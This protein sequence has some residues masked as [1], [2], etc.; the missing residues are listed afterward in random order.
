[1]CSSSLRQH[2]TSLVL[3][4]QGILPPSHQSIIT[5]DQF[6]RK[7]NLVALKR[8]LETSDFYGNAQS[9]L[10]ERICVA[11]EG[12]RKL[13]RLKEAVEAGKRLG[14]RLKAKAFH[15]WLRAKDFAELDEHFQKLKGYTLRL[16]KE[17][18]ALTSALPKKI[19]IET[20]QTKIPAH[21][22]AQSTAVRREMVE[23][24]DKV[25]TSFAASSTSLS[26]KPQDKSAQLYDRLYR[27]AAKR[28]LVNS[29]IRL[30]KEER[31]KQ[32]TPFKPSLSASGSVS[33]LPVFERLTTSTPKMK[34]SDR[35]RM[36]ADREMREC[37]F[38]P[39]LET[40]SRSGSLARS[41]SFERLYEDAEMKRQ[42]KRLVER[43]HEQKS[44]DEC[45]F[46]P[47]VNSA[48]SSFSSDNVFEKLYS[49]SPI[50]SYK[51]QLRR[52]QDLEVERSSQQGKECPF[53]PQLST[54]FK[55]H[56]SVDELPY[57]RMHKE[58]ELR[59]TRLEELKTRIEKE[60]QAKVDRSRSA[61]KKRSE[62]SSPFR[63]GREDGS[64]LQDKRSPKAELQSPAS[65]PKPEPRPVISVPK[66]ETSKAAPGASKKPD[67]PVKPSKHGDVLRTI[68]EELTSKS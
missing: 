50:Q 55:Q 58:G 5:D 23:I 56:R 51:S 16:I 12:G 20:N 21:S 52:K 13:E 57:E 53:V 30:L 68:Y 31:E 35:E 15:K 4:T 47:T 3:P 37:T 43:E 44:L 62:Q 1:M 65:L 66:A 34:E 63:V 10:A 41:G 67:P 27:E 22:Y 36:R 25:P 33:D 40:R 28:E 24:P 59:K 8:F 54:S 14:S 29:Q 61:P 17:N 9:D 48:K 6:N 45:T 49:V 32:E 11:W 39:Q 60:E 7:G 64:R 18:K 38:T 19:V 46:R 26:P 2:L 42:N